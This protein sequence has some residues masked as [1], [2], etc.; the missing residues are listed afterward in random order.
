MQ[1]LTA[2]EPHLKFIEYI[3]YNE[4]A[5]REAVE[6]ARLHLPKYEIRNDNAIGDPTASE[7]I[8]NLM[9]VKLIVLDGRKIYHPEKWLEVID[10]TRQYCAKHGELYT[11]IFK[12]R[13][14]SVYYA[15]TCELLNINDNKFYRI[16]EKIR[17]Y[18]SLQAAYHHLI[19]L[20]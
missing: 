9:P 10:K 5:I 17:H 3:L 18:A 7:V 15:H 2:A 8:K 16:L 6:E 4:A 19:Y 13:Y 14:G 20:E 11:E 12:S 1:R